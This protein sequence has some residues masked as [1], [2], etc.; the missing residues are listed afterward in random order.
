MDYEQENWSTISPMRREAYN[1]LRLARYGLPPIPPPVVDLWVV[2]SPTQPG[3]KTPQMRPF[4]E[5]KEAELVA[6]FRQDRPPPGWIFTI[7]GKT[8]RW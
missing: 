4:D 8:T 3:T 6:S 7:N 5:T 2:P 1:K